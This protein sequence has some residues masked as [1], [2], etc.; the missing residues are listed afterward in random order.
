MVIAFAL[1]LLLL[2][3]FANVLDAHLSIEPWLPAVILGVALLTGVV[4]GLY[5][6]ICA[7]RI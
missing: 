2:P 3:V 6:G 7:L 1:V 4:A 5:P